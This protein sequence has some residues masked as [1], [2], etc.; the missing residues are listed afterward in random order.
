MTKNACGSLARVKSFASGTPREDSELWSDGLPAAPLKP[1]D[2]HIIRVSLQRADADPSLLEV[3]DN[4]ERERARRFVFDRDRS[5]FIVSHAALRTVLGHCLTVDPVQLTFQFGLNGKPQLAD[6]ENDVRFNLSHAGDYALIAV[7]L[8]REVGVDIELVR[9]IDVPTLSKR[10][11]SPVEAR[12]LAGLPREAALEAFFR[13][14]TRKESFIK[15]LGSG[16]SLALDRFSVSLDETY[17]PLRIVG[18]D[19]AVDDR[20]MMLAL[21]APADYAA[22]ITFEGMPWRQNLWSP[23]RLR[24]VAQQ[25]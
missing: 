10:F 18:E 20:W 13:C 3:L 11:F 22:A 12:I 9:P 16:L 2:V 17:E 8:G 7:A 21:P 14:W 19:S 24:R 15:A 6:S 23:S 4:S 1:V 5:R 25:R